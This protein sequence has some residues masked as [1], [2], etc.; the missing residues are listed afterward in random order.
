M[1]ENVPDTPKGKVRFDWYE[2]DTL[3]DAKY[4][5]G[6]GYDFSLNEPWQ[7]G[8][9]ES[10]LDEAQRQL[11]ALD[12]TDQFTEIEWWVSNEDVALQLQELLDENG[13]GDIT[14]IWKP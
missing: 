8:I 7:E 9:K 5:E 3:I 11:K 6:A 4:A 13:L 2:G 1:I 10:L 14:V 12:S